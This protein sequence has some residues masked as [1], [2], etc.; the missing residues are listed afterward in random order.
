MSLGLIRKWILFQLFS[1]ICL[2]SY[3]KHW[4]SFKRIFI[5]CN[6]HVSQTFRSKPSPFE[7]LI[8]MKL[9]KFHIDSVC[10]SLSFTVT[11]WTISPIKEILQRAT[12]K[13]SDSSWPSSADLTSDVLS[14]LIV[15]PD[16]AVWQ[17][18]RMVL[19]HAFFP[20][21]KSVWEKVAL[22]VNI[23]KICKPSPLQSSCNRL[24]TC[25]SVI[26]DRRWE[27][28]SVAA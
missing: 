23:P 7:V 11:S 24:N 1:L 26:W 28:K 27:K 6:W 18:V 22:F 15:K 25:C 10:G 16:G 8:Q 13:F 14:H 21:S 2:Y 17:F 20:Q 4:V 12:A 9:W 3:I 5:L 19:Y